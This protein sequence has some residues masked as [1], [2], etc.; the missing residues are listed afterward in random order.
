MFVI[1]D[2]TDSDCE[3]LAADG[4]QTDHSPPNNLSASQTISLSSSQQD[5][6]EESDI[7]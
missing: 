1:S 6:C 3:E 7:R 5:S 4:V 2:E